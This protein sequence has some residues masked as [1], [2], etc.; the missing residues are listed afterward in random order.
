MGD[1]M[2]FLYDFTLAR[3]EVISD[4]SFGRSNLSKYIFCQRIL[5]QIPLEEMADRTSMQSYWLAEIE[6]DAKKCFTLTCM[7]LESIA[8]VL[9]STFE[10]SEGRFKMKPKEHDLSG[11]VKNSL[12]NLYQFVISKAK[13]LSDESILKEWANY[14]D[15]DVLPVKKAARGEAKELTEKDW[16]K[17]FESQTLF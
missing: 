15:K 8:N 2:G 6:K 5:K 9:D 11:P 14:W 10:I 1:I 7:Q 3:R 12:R 4:G 13:A 17:R 16:K